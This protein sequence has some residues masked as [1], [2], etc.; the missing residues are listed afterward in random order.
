MK[1]GPVKN[2]KAASDCAAQEGYRVY[3]T[4]HFLHSIDV[5]YSQVNMFHIKKGN[6]AINIQIV[7]CNKNRKYSPP[8]LIDTY[9]DRSYLL[10]KGKYGWCI[11]PVW[12]E[13]GIDTRG[14][15]FT[16]PDDIR[17]PC[18]EKPGAGQ[19]RDH[20]STTVQSHPRKINAIFRSGPHEFCRQQVHQIYPEH[21]ANVPQPTPYK[22]YPAFL[23]YWLVYYTLKM[24]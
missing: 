20:F 18:P 15:D 14:T 7:G 21:T 6:V 9:D 5:P 22:S 8:G 24:F 1:P 12:M 10:R 11:I 23:G 19:E 3:A 17:E 16:N 2:L 13:T 4:K